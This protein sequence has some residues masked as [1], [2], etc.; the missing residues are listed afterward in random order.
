MNR[1][2]GKSGDDML[3]CSILACVAV[4]FGGDLGEEPP[5]LTARDVGFSGWGAVPEK[6]R[7]MLREKAGWKWDFPNEPPEYRARQE[8]RKSEILQLKHYQERVDNWVQYTQTRTVKNFTRNGFDVVKA[9]ADLVERLR[10]RLF[11]GLFGADEPPEDPHAELK[12]RPESR[13]RG[14]LCTRILD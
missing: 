13:P 3:R 4:V 10:K 12:G 8:M 14:S 7:V 6:K 5:K 2:F 9:P 1:R 11:Q